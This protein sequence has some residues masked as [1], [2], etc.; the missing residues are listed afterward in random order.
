L[1]TRAG[2]LAALLCSL[3]L[4]A[5]C[6]RSHAIVVGSKNFT[7]QL[8]LG[9]IIAQQIENQLHQKVVRRFN[10]GGSLLAHQALLAK[11]VDVYPEY[12]G[13]AFAA[14]L[15]HPPIPDAAIVLERVR[16][17]YAANYA[18]KWCDP[19]GFNDSFAMVIRGADARSGHYVALSDAERRRDPWTLAVGYEFLTRADGYEA[20]MAIYPQLHWTSFPKTMDLGLLY[21]ALE[22]GQVS[23]VAANTT[24]GMLSA[25]D[26]KVLED[27]RKAFPPYQASIVAR[28]A[29]L[30]EHPGLEAALTEL[31]GK[32]DGKEIQ[33]LNYEVDGNHR[34]A[35]DVAAEFLRSLR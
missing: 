6:S 30:Q 24:D 33:K 3:A 32:I 29:A 12:T 18:L 1:K 13:T 21:R 27:D 17:E 31:S 26:V 14:I 28:F 10:L 4:L 34:P 8:V 5:G 23:M 2:I 25:L 35:H 7:E 20:L 16:T 19:L 15:K 9:E 22:Q 11:E